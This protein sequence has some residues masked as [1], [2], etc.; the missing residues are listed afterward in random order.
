MLHL[1][2]DNL[3]HWYCVT[4]TH[5][6]VTMAKTA[7]KNISFLTSRWVVAYLIL[8]PF[9]KVP[10]K[11]TVW[12]LNHIKY[13]MKKEETA[14]P[15]NMSCVARKFSLPFDDQVQSC[16]IRHRQKTSWHYVCP[17][18]NKG[19]SLHAFIFMSHAWTQPSKHT[20]K[21]VYCPSSNPEVQNKNRI[22]V[23]SPPTTDL[24]NAKWGSYY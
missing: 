9:S 15:K 19:G 5:V 8:C 22:K 13:H 1:T 21:R 18:A 12:F 2:R 17:R 14:L 11:R 20:A 16:T 23:G 3:L 6:S 4:L 24:H 7:S 10:Y